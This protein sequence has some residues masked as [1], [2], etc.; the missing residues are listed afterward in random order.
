MNRIPGD[1]LDSG[2]GGFVQALHTKGGYLIKRGATVLESIVGCPGR[3]AECLP[4]SLALIATTLSP[5]GFVKAVANDGFG[6]ALSR[7]RQCVLGQLRLFTVGWAL[8]TPELM[9]SN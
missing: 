7:G 3:R 5:P 2:N 8:E 1:A 6:V 4:T 9:A